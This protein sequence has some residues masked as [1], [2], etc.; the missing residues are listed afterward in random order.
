MANDLLPGT[1]NVVRFPV[2]ERGRPTLDLMRML[3]PDVRTLD[4]LTD[5]YGLELPAFDFRDRVDAEAA[6]HILNHL[7]TEPGAQRTAQLQEMLEPL[8]RTAVE[9]ARGA[10]RAWSAVGAGR[11]QV[12][13]AKR[14]GGFWMQ[15]LEEQLNIQE[16]QAAE[17]TI[18]A[19]LR[20]EEAEG[21]ARAVHLAEG[22]Q[23]WIPRDVAADMDALLTG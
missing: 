22:C 17:A 10:R 12:M 1:T 6:E 8:V 7:E 20:A 23:V 18:E 4:M 14:D 2:E 16:R 11:R 19:H 13:Q 3:A 15:A 9:A 21:V 5:A